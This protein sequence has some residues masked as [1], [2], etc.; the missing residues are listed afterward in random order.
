MC[1]YQYHNNMK[2]KG[3]DHE[4]VDLDDIAFVGHCGM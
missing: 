4:T 3:K 2:Y 1:H